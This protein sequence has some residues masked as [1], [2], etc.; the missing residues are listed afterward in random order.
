MLA[1]RGAWGQ[2]D[3]AGESDYGGR[4]EK[5]GGKTFKELKGFLCILLQKTV[6]GGGGYIFTVPEDEDSKNP[7]LCRT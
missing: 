2:L 1:S 4:G 3:H 7:E 5:T 6:A